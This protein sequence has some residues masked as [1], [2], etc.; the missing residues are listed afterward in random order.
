MTQPDTVDGTNNSPCI[1][2]KKTFVDAI[3]NI[4]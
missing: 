2:V 4:A 3:L 1:K